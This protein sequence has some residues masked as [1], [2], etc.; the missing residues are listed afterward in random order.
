MRAAAYFLSCLTALALFAR[1]EPPD[2]RELVRA[3]VQKDQLNAN[4]AK[5]YTYV[6]RTETRESDAL[7]TV[8]NIKSETFDVMMIG[9]E[10]FRKLTAR[11]D[12]PLTQSEARK[13]ERG[14]EKAISRHAAN[15]A[16]PAKDDDRS[17]AFVQELPEAF[18]FTFVGEELIDGRPVWVIDASPKP[19]YR[20]SAKR[21]ELLTKFRGRLWI[22][23]TELQW[24]RVEAE[25]VAPV[26]FGW[27]LA[28]LAP[29]AKVTFQQT[30]VNSELWL[31][32]KAA[33][34]GVVRLGFRTLRS[35][36][37][38]VW[39]DYRKYRTDSRIVSTEAAPPEPPPVRP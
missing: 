21:W 28:R 25:T 35:Q 20:G 10:Q 22:D 1:A 39:K 8:K 31:P 13:A 32:S 18:V 11:N 23:Q 9:E 24:V 34:Q 17:R 3:S 14:F 4:R 6:Q 30:R 38:V 7:G 5:D 16:K 29:G 19:G 2:L 36:T 26:T 27:V 33:T 15:S 37:V 12:V